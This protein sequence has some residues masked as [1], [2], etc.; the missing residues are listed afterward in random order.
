MRLPVLTRRQLLVLPL[1]LAWAPLARARAEVRRR[2]AGYVVDC[3]ILYD[4][5]TFRLTGTIDES[6]DRDE[7]RY[8][9]R[10]VGTG[11]G[12]SNRVESRGVLRDGRWV[13]L[14]YGAQFLVAGRESRLEIGY[15][16]D[17]RRIDFK[18]RAETF[19]L[20]RLRVVDDVLAMPD[21]TPV[22]DIVTAAL[23][24]ADGSWRPRR[25]GAFETLVA[26][27]R[28]A[29]NEGTDDAEGSYRAELVPFVLTVKSD[30]AGGRAVAVIDLSRFSSWAR[31]NE[32][33]RVVFDPDRRPETI[34]SSLILGTTIAI[35]IAPRDQPARS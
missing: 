34:T 26:R 29:R 21:G 20:R 3:G 19:I 14:H 32:P 24:Y 23:N 31:V 35:R 27:R 4:V 33:T 17:R 25:D 18:S 1:A 28:R 5:F 16:H 7:G 6:V 13:P 22:D 10:I 2:G 11:P 8:E 12:I 15:D 30:P 9:V